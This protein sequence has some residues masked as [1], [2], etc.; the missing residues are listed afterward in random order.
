MWMAVVTKKPPNIPAL[1]LAM[2]PRAELK[3]FGFAGIIN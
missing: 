2:R 1:I 3:Y